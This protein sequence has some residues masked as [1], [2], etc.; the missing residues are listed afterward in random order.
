LDE[1][2][3]TVLIIGLLALVGVGFFWIFRRRG[4]VSISALSTRLEVEGS[5]EPGAPAPGIHGEE[6]KAG[7]NIKAIDKTGRG[8]KV[9]KAEAQGDIGL[10]NQPPV[11]GSDPKP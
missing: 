2:T 9:V 8:V 7:G 3:A 10:T 1:L 4:K 6:L 11:G 5:N